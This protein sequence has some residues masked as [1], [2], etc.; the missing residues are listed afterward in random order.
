MHHATLTAPGSV[1]Y[2]RRL[3][4][5]TGFVLHL[6]LLVRGKRGVLSIERQTP[7]RPYPE[8]G[9]TNRDVATQKVKVTPSVVQS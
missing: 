2:L 1:G 3:A 4:R 6:L 7:Q 8:F 5:S 9:Q